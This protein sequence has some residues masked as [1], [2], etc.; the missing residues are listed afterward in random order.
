MI[1]GA[2]EAGAMVIRELQTHPEMQ[3]KPVVAVD[4]NPLKHK[5]R[6]KGVPILG[7]RRTYPVWPGQRE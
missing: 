7:G 1:V 4:D 3:M 6:I 5:S 2:G